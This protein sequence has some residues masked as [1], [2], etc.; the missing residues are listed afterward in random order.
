MI[1]FFDCESSGKYDFSSHS[2]ADHQPHIVSLA[3]ICFSDEGQYESHVLSSIIRPD[4][5]IISDEA[6]AVHDISTEYALANGIPFGLALLRRMPSTG[7]LLRPGTGRRVH[8]LEPFPAH[9]TPSRSESMS[10]FVIRL[11][12]RRGLRQN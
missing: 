2:S 3:S 4:G 1:Q 11:C 10:S 8:N 5:W 7:N 9:D 12:S 6:T